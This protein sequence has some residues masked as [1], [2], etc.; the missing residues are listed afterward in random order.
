VLPSNLEGLPLTLLEAGSHGTPVVASDIAPHLEV[1]GRERSGQRLFTSGSRDSLTAALERSLADPLEERAGADRFRER[2]LAGYSWDR[3][4]L[5][6]ESVYRMVLG[7]YDSVLDLRVR[8]RQSELEL[9]QADHD[10]QAAAPIPVTTETA[11][12]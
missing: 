6:T 2:V 1:L 5:A 8:E 4:V 11:A 7:Q 3:A 12:A 10:A 9:E